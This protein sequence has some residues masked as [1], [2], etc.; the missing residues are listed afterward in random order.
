MKKTFFILFAFFCHFFA[1][2]WAA[3]DSKWEHVQPDETCSYL[4][5]SQAF[6]AHLSPNSSS[7]TDREL[8]MASWGSYHC[9]RIQALFSISQQLAK[10]V[11]NLESKIETLEN[12]LRVLIKLVD[13]N[14]RKI[15]DDE[16]KKVTRQLK[17]MQ[18]Q[19]KKNRSDIDEYER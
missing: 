14:L 13:E 1:Q 7:P 12:E 10:N 11:E 3:L 6:D 19:V 9:Y 2:T 4:D 8:H 5:P 15:F 17:S 18:E 16:I